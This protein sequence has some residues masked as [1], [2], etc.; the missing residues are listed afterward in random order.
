MFIVELIMDLVD[1][2]FLPSNADTLSR[3]ND[4]QFVELIL[5]TTEDLRESLKIP[6][7]KVE[8][9]SAVG[10]AMMDLN[11]P[12]WDQE[13]ACA[14]RQS[15]KD[16]V[17]RYNS[18]S[19]AADYNTLLQDIPPLVQRHLWPSVSVRMT[20]VETLVSWFEWAKL[21][22]SAVE[23]R[24]EVG[25][26]YAYLPEPPEAADYSDSEDSDSNPED[27]TSDEQPKDNTVISVLARFRRERRKAFKE[28]VGTTRKT[29]SKQ[30]RDFKETRQSTESRRR[31]I[32]KFRFLNSDLAG[33][34]RAKFPET[35]A[36][37]GLPILFTKLAASSAAGPPLTSAQDHDGDTTM[38]MH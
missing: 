9:R 6:A 32:P 28:L 1:T 36:Q 38:Q 8:L 5:A 25:S 29:I 12:K 14:G 15:I 30:S 4:M 16:F 7:S 2:D 18:I 21:W 27:P 11:D 23:Q 35:W 19:Q 33:G 17:H 22:I 20:D 24:T 3:M 26:G 37:S 31:A 13:S 34:Y 10:D